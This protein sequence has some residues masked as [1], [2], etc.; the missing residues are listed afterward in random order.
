MNEL[1]AVAA[2][3]ATSLL[4]TLGAVFLA[5]EEETRS[6]VTPYLIALSTGAIFG[7]A[8]IHL[9][10]KYTAKYGYSRFTGMVIAASVGLSF[11][12][13][14]AIHWHCHHSDHSIEPFSYMVLLGDAIHNVFDGIIIASAFLISFDAGV[15][16]SIGVVLHK[17]PKEMGDFGALVQG[18]FTERKA[19]LFNLGVGIFAIL[20]GV[21]V[22]AF[23]G[24]EFV[25]NL[26]LPVG[27]GSFIYIAGTDLFPEIK[28][29]EMDDRIVAVLFFGGVAVMYSIVLVK[30]FLG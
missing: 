15:V 23:S 6:R 12:L 18:G 20:G 21:I 19:L 11:F 14:K 28:E 9:I 1:W 4:A 16:A 29:T 13:E 2:I 7:G 5:F 27:I 25:E 30:S 3:A 26:L 10:P 8:F 22:L 17:I 24:T